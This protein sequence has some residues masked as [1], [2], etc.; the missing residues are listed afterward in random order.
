MDSKCLYRILFQNNQISMMLIDSSTG[1]IVEVNQAAINFYGYTADQFQEMSITDINIMDANQIRKEM[2]KANR[3][4]NKYFRFTHKLANNEYRQVEVYSIR[5]EIDNKE[6][7]FSTIYDIS[8]KVEQELML[9]TLFFNSPYAVVTLSGNKEIVNINQNF[10]NLFQYSLDEV[11]GG[12]LKDF[13]SPFENSEEIDNNLNLILK[14]EILKQEA[15]RK[16]KNGDLINVEILGYPIINQNTIKG[17]Y[18]IYIDNTEK[19][20]TKINCTFLERYYKILL[21]AL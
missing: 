1:R 2:D 16:N 13:I 12:M 20:F 11:K 15:I 7:L 6:L 17:F 14:G 5:V 8:D 10:A 3:G 21:R 9:D 18:I 4:D 19:K